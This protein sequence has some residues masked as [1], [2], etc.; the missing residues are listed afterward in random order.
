VSAHEAITLT[1]D[2][3]RPSSVVIHL[4][5]ALPPS[6]P[7]IDVIEVHRPSGS[8]LVSSRDVD[9]VQVSM[10]LHEFSHLRML[11]ARPAGKAGS[12]LIEA[13]EEAV[14]DYYAAT[15]Q[16]SALLGSSARGQRDLNSVPL[17]S[18]GWEAL[19]IDSLHFDPHEVGL[20]LSSR[21]WRLSKK[22]GLLLEDLITCMKEARFGE[23]DSPRL[24]LASWLAACPERSRERI[25]QQLREWIPS[26]LY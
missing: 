8:V 23:V 7:A 22:P 5:P 6:A 13:V 24:V 16:G 15:I 21:L 25:D 4:D 20:G 19:A 11:G 12:Q 1:P 17:A 3:L 10:W 26:E 18:H 2:K 9:Q 14:A